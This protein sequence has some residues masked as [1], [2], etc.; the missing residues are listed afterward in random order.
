VK[1]IQL[2]GCGILACLAAASSNNKKVSD[3]T[4]SG[5]LMMVL[6]AMS[7]HGSAMD[8]QKAGLQALYCQ[9]ALSTN[10]ES[11]K[12]SLMESRLDSGRSGIE[13]IVSAMEKLQDDI[14]AMEWACRMCWCL[15]SSEDLVK[16]ISVTQMVLGRVLQTCQRHLDNPDAVGLVEASFGVLGNLA[17]VESN[18]SELQNIGAIPVIIDGMRYHRNDYGVNI[19]ACSAIANLAVSTYIRDSIV[20]A[21][22]VGTVIR[23]MQSF[24]ESA[25]FVGEA[26]RA[27][28]CMA[29]HSQESKETMAIPEVISYVVHASAKHEGASLTQE[30]SSALLA[31]LAVGRATSDV[32]I[33]CGGVDVLIRSL[34]NPEEKVQDAACV[35]YR[36]LS[37]QV[38]DSDPLLQ[39]GAIKSIVNAMQR[40]DDSVSIQLNACYSLWNLAFKAQKEPG[41]IVGSQGIKC[42]VKAM[43]SH[44]ESGDLLEIACGALWS[45]VDDSIERKKDVVGNGAIDAVAVAMVMHPSR[46]STLEKACGVLSNLSFEGPLADAIANAQGVSI[47]V[48]AMRNNG[49][50][51]SLLE[52]GCIALRNIV[53]QFPNYAQEASAVVS[54][55]INA[56]RDNIDAVGF[57][58]E[59][60]NLL[61]LLAA[62][63]ESCN[64]KILALD[65][66]AVLMK[67]LEHNSYVPEV[68]DAALGAFNQLAKNR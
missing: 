31:S 68:Q 5:A 34:A 11:N 36:N 65:G 23:A 27:M 28:V 21:G 64:S 54:T 33:E 60:C 30:M 43:Q 37:C 40:H 17:H 44:M 57:Q 19:E 66:I 22:G 49:S 10:A 2:N 61:W 3:G 26:T 63:A 32:I 55:I 13:V 46:T 15:T 53:F 29:I 8:I 67:C 24:M 1:S 16:S 62:E 41:A 45:L 42:I 51:I 38:L 25:E 6:N 20:K 39:K 12:R 7:F 50:S 18:R 4:L 9:C 14:V 58:Q 48:E 59:A 35:A 52:V 56:M 47:V